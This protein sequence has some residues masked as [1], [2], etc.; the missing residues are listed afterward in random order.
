M[1]TVWYSMEKASELI[2]DLPSDSEN[3]DLSNESYPDFE[4]NHEAL[5][6]NTGWAEPHVESEE[7]NEHSDAQSNQ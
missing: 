2:L 1:S 3:A 5:P 6:S 4:T 7:E